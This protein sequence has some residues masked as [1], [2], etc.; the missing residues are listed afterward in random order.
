MLYNYSTMTSDY[1]GDTL[2]GLI[3]KPCVSNL[4]NAILALP[5]ISN[6][7]VIYYHDGGV[8]GY[9]DQNMLNNV[10]GNIGSWCRPDIVLI[11]DNEVDSLALANSLRK[12]CEDYEQY[13]IQNLSWTYNNAKEFLIHI[14]VR[15]KR[16]GGTHTPEEIIK[17]CIA[18]AKKVPKRVAVH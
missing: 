6:K 9:I 14:A 17:H 12:I 10:I 15:A 8:C 1:F 7:S 18:I 3:D 5:S 13:S 2:C 4:R 16:I 11:F